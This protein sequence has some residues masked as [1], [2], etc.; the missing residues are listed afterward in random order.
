MEEYPRRQH[1]L[2][3]LLL[4]IAIIIFAA[5]NSVIAKLGLLGA[6]HLVNGRNPISFCNV[7]FAGNILAGLAL[8]GIPRKSWNR[9]M[10]S[11]LTGMNWLNMLILAILSGVIGPTLFFLGLML[12][13][14]INVVLV[15]VLDIPL[16]LIL[17]WII[18]KERPSVG[19]TI[20]ALLAL[21]GIVVEFFLHQPDPMPMHMRMTMIN[22]GTGPVAHFLV[23]L[24]K[25]GEIC[26]ALATFF[27]V[28]SVEFSR[29]AFSNVPVGI[30]SVFR[31]I[32]GAIIF[33]FVVIIMLGWVHFIDIFNLF[34]LEW[35]IVY[36]VGIIALGLYLWY[37]ALRDTSA[38]DLAIANSFSPIAGIVF[39]FLILGEIP[40]FGQIVG[41]VIILVGI[42]VGLYAK[43]RKEKEEEIGMRKPRS[44]SGV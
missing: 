8:L 12:T 35:M 37:K 14:V 38:G 21:C 19:S 1:Y 9:G 27:T 2:S 40:E 20:A 36:G 23:A 16:T 4:W 39:A 13:D 34:L 29:K 11:Q 44:F 25:A 41:G 3:L 42:G 43:L 17:A 31:M 10:L 18:L 28:F 5:A 30:Y 22:I 26:V 6:H 7:L 24:P 15:S 32:V 33:F